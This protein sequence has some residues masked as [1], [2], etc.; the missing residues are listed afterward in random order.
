[1]LVSIDAPDK[2]I[3]H[4]PHEREFRAWT[5]RLLPDEYDAILV[6]LNDKISG[7]EVHT[8]SWMPG[9]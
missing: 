4:I 7:G 8:S 2:P 6:A 1:M 9:T 3:T 5:S